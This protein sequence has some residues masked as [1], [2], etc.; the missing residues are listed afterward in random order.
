MCF[1]CNREVDAYLKDLDMKEVRPIKKSLKERAERLLGH[2]VKDTSDVLRNADT[3]QQ[4][5]WWNTDHG[6]I[7]NDEEC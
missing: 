3:A 6:V 2:D 1:Q 4:L 5:P 7:D